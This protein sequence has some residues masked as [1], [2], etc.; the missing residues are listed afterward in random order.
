MPCVWWIWL[1][2]NSTQ[3]RSG[4]RACSLVPSRESVCAGTWGLPAGPKRKNGW[5]PAE[6]AGDVSP[7]GTPHLLRHADWDV[8]EV[9][10]DV[11]DYVTEAGSSSNPPPGSALQVRCDASR[12]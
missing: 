8:D 1:L 10:D 9:R 5:T 7:A 2:M 11:L 6:H 4:F 3:R 12:G